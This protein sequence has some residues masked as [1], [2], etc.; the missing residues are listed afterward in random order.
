MAALGRFVRAGQPHPDDALW[1]R[2]I[3]AGS[4]EAEYGAEGCLVGVPLAIHG[5]TAGWVGMAAGRALTP[6]G[7]AALRSLAAVASAA[8]ERVGMGSVAAAGPIRA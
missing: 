4:V 5:S 3:A 7:Y 1:K 2:V 8:A 6:D